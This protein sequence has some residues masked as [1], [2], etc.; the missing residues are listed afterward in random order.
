M[1]F[2]SQ[3]NLLLELSE[4]SEIPAIQKQIDELIEELLNKFPEECKKVGLS[5]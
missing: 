4:V 1:S 3:F 5:K 2:S